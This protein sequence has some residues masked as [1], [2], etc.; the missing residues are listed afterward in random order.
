VLRFDVKTYSPSATAA[1]IVRANR[2]GNPAETGYQIQLG[3][4]DAQWPFGSVAGHAKGSNSLPAGAWIPIEVE[5]SGGSITV[6]SG[7]KTLATASGL[8][9]QAGLVG[10][11]SRHGPR[12]EI[13]NLRARLLRPQ[14]LFNGADLTG[15]KSTGVEAKKGGGIP[16]LGKVFGKASRSQPRGRPRPG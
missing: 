7:D 4:G 14:S 12:I 1:L 16:I 5:V 13:R 10:L 8:Q 9:G 3:G 2:D 6:R 11:E 15:W